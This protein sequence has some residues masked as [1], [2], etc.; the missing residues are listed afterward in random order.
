MDAYFMRIERLVNSDALDSRLR[1][2]LMD[3]VDMRARR[4][5][6]RRKAEGPKRIDEV[7][8]EARREAAAAAARAGSGRLGGG[9]PPPPPPSYERGGPS[10]RREDLPT[11]P[12]GAGLGARQASEELSFRPATYSRGGPPPGG[13]PG[14][15]GRGGGGPGGPGAPPIG[16]R[17][18]GPP[19]MGGGRGAGATGGASASIPEDSAVGGGGGAGRGRGAAVAAAPAAAAAGAGAAAA[20]A[21]AGGRGSPGA[22]ASRPSGGAVGDE[23]VTRRVKGVAEALT[24]G[25][26]EE[27]ADALQRLRADGADMALAVRRLLAQAL[28][29]RG[30]PV[31]ERLERLKPLL[32]DLL[33]SAEEQQQQGGEGGDG[34]ADGGEGGDSGADGGEGSDGGADGGVVLTEAEFADGCLRFLGDLPG[35]AEELLKAPVLTA[36]F[37][38]DFVADGTLPLADVGAALIASKGAGNGGGS[39]DAGAGDEGGAGDEDEEDGGLVEQGFAVPMVAR[40][41]SG[42]ASARGEDA[43]REQWRASGLAWDALLPSFERG[44]GDASEKAVRRELERH[45]SVF[46]LGEGGAAAA[47]A[48]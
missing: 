20:A 16:G 41:L 34:G 27:A 14:G 46:V 35:I 23:E 26:A 12:I 47:A 36:A 44:Q 2:L 18:A 31:E 17:G 13:P 39:E 43:A 30:V 25:N 42:V 40:V 21:S 45:G 11:K 19:G 15:G 6:T 1:F 33:A 4:W 24:M 7:H 5:E 3:V 9:G 8:R 38:A 28:D 22:S 32:S 37:L 29:V 10:L 48:E